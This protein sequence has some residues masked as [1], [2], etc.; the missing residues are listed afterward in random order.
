MTGNCQPCK[1]SKQIWH[2]TAQYWLDCPICAN[3]NT[4]NTMIKEDAIRENIE[5]IVVTWTTNGDYL[6]P[7]R[8]ARLEQMLMDKY[9]VR[10][11]RNVPDADL[12]KLR[13]DIDVLIHGGHDVAKD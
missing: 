7:Q 6:I 9:G 3:S 13:T 5:E 10:R 8:A 1:G 12:R 4:E 2:P 11:V